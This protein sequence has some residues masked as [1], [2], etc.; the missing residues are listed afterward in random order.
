[1]EFTPLSDLRR[2]DVNT[3]VRICVIRKW[4]FHGISG[5][6]PIQHV[7]L[8]LA[9]EKVCSL[10]PMNYNIAHRVHYFTHVLTLFCKAIP[11]LQGSGRFGN[12]K[13]L[14]D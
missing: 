11:Y 4:D 10:I 1:M 5:N 12:G 2:H 13:K 8:V 9:D 3:V 14:L 7:D 6:G